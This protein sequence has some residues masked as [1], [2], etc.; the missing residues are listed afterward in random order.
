MII[1]VAGDTTAAHFDY[2]SGVKAATSI[3]GSVAFHPPIHFRPMD[4]PAAV[5]VRMAAPES[6]KPSLDPM[7]T[8][9]RAIIDIAGLL[10]LSV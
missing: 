8:V 10:P 3:W 2:P 6:V 7:I 4:L 1:Q 9:R 5:A